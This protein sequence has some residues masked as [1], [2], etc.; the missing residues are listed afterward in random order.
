V[1]NSLTGT[2]GPI[3]IPG[4]RKNG[5]P[6]WALERS[7]TGPGKNPFLCRERSFKGRDKKRLGSAFVREPII[8]ESEKKGLPRRT[9][10]GM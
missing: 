4:F 9:G 1:S 7:L 10:S 2:G 6:G 3:L 5:F 8:Q